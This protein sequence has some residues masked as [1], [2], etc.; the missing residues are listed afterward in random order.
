M[1]DG[2]HGTPPNEPRPRAGVRHS[3]PAL[4]EDKTQ[5]EIW[6]N[7]EQFGDVLGITARMVEKDSTIPRA[8]F[9]RSKTGEPVWSL[10]VVKQVCDARGIDLSARSPVLR[11]RAQLVILMAKMYPSIERDEWREVVAKLADRA[12]GS[13]VPRR[14]FSPTWD[15][16]APRADDSTVPSPPEPE[17]P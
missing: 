7:A 1:H 14:F 13:V 10:D 9:V 2:N 8:R 6:H 3:G 5:G 11:R 15:E 16:F 17:Q 4:S 12:V